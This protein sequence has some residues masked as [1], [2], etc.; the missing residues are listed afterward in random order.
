MKHASEMRWA[1]RGV[2]G[3]RSWRR[4]VTGLAL[5]L[6][7]LVVALVAI[8]PVAI[9]GEDTHALLAKARTERVLDMRPSAAIIGQEQASAES[10]TVSL[11]RVYRYEEEGLEPLRAYYQPRLERRGWTRPTELQGGRGIRFTKNIDGR[12]WMFD[13]QR[14]SGTGSYEVTMWAYY[15]VGALG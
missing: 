3:R 10:G 6:A 14:S 5:A 2:S 11:V 8:R 9:W 1:R 4:W 7:A 12:E 15:D 13:V